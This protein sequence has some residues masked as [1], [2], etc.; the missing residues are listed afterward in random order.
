MLEKEIPAASSAILIS[1][2]WNLVKQAAVYESCLLCPSFKLKDHRISKGKKRFY[3]LINFIR[4]SR[5]RDV[6]RK[7]GLE[8]LLQ[9]GWFF[10]RQ[11]AQVGGQ[12]LT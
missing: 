12:S 7:G 2:G 6:L 5:G 1:A 3:S 4:K 9:A 10:S 8:R 11:E